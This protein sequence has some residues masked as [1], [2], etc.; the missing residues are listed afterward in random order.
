MDLLELFLTILLFIL[1][2][3]ITK[4]GVVVM[5]RAALSKRFTDNP[6]NERK[7][8]S[9]H[10]PTLGGIVF[11]AALWLV[12]SIHPQSML[13]DGFGYLLASSI[14]LFIIA[15]KDDL[16]LLAPSKKII[17]QLTAA[18]FMI[19]GAGIYVETFGGVFGVETLPY[20]ASVVVSI[21]VYVVVT[22]AVNLIDGVD[23]LAATVVIAC[24][25]FFSFWFFTAGIY[26]LALFSLFFAGAMGGF[27]WHN[28][29]PATVFMGDTGALLSGFYLAF[30]GIE[31]LNTAVSA[32]VEF[33]WQANTPA[34]LIAILIVPLYDTLRVFII[35][36]LKGRSP[37]KADAE[38]IHH[39]LLNTGLNHTQVT[40]IIVGMQCI[41]VI[42]AIVLS[43]FMSVNYLLMTIIALS[44]VVFPTMSFKRKILSRITNIEFIQEKL[45]RD[46]V[47]PEEIIAEGREGTAKQANPK[48]EKQGFGKNRES[49]IHVAG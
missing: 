33:T 19:F 22:N 36:V 31:F 49:A 46:K 29:E 10:V 16:F 24:S 12:F 17:A 45:Y 48:T 32:P 27:L 37:F 25:L 23:G 43:H 30:L 11:I 9:D 7:I 18:F 8:H 44:V 5:V 20:T 47:K 6:E 26:P 39:E 21:A 1:A 15:I 13:F 28:R 2:F 35:R 4:R 40:L 41:I 38:H 34:I 3:F 42:A 14:V